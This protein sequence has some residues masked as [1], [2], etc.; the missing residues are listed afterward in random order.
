MA[1]RRFTL[2]PHVVTPAPRELPVVD[3]TKVTIERVRAENK[4][5]GQSLLRARERV[6]SLEAMLKAEQEAHAFTRKKFAE[7]RAGRTSVLARKKASGS[8]IAE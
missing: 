2:H 3:G 8:K 4:N 6:A 1:Y 5:L 7:L